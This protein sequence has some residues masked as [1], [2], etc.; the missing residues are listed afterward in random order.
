MTYYYINEMCSTVKELAVK[1]K[2]AAPWI[3]GDL[4]MPDINWDTITQ[5]AWIIDCLNM[6]QTSAFQQ[7]VTFP[8]FLIC[9]LQ[10]VR[11]LVR[12]SAKP[13]Q[14][15]RSLCWQPYQQRGVNLWRA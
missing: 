13:W 1:N 6:V 8:I 5:S 4:K 14:S 15:W 11:L 12:P 10:T 9:S 3:A 7:M 2:K